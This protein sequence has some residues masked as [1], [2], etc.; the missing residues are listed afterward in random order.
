MCAKRVS[1]FWGSLSD[2]V[3]QDRAS[4]LKQSYADQGPVS[5]TH[6][7]WKSSLVRGGPHEASS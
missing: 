1:G 6:T 7:V 3:K 4:L 5:Q 2:G